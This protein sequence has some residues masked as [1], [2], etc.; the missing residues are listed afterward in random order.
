[1]AN[2]NQKEEKSGK[3]SER[4][5]NLIVRSNIRKALKGKI[6]NV[7]EEVEE[8]LNNKVH[9]ILE[10]AVERAKANQRRTIQARDL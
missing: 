1:M 3:S 9:E 6:D 5:I 7:A 2:E 4:K 8:A 10:V